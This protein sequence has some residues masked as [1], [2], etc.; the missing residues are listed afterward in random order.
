MCRCTCNC[1]L[2]NAH[3]RAQ[4]QCS[5]LKLGV[6]LPSPSYSISNLYSG[7]HRVGMEIKYT[8]LFLVF[9]R[10]KTVFNDPS[11]KIRIKK[12]QK[13]KQFENMFLQ[14]WYKYRLWVTIIICKLTS[15]DDAI[16][17]S[18]SCWHLSLK[19]PAV[20]TGKKSLPLLF[21]EGDLVIDRCLLL[22]QQQDYFSS[23][24]QPLIPPCQVLTF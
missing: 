16:I 10:W 7:Q 24:A 21:W 23:R 22:W 12:Q 9:S 1:T 18:L 15:N 6:K 17:T 11:N 8:F 20:S 2:H 5:V 14:V 13:K 3:C 19:E 4:S